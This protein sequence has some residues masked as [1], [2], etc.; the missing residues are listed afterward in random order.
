MTTQHLIT[1][2]QNEQT[3]A[4]NF[5][6]NNSYKLQPGKQKNEQNGPTKKRSEKHGFN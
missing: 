5:N 2:R 6:C 4:N 1:E 3:P